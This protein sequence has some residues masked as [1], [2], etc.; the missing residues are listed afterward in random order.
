[1]NRIYNEVATIYN[2]TPGEVEKE[3]RLAIIAAKNNPAPTARA[4][5]SKVADGADVAEVVDKIISRIALVV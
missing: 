4:F 2:T 1:M 5:W 3:I